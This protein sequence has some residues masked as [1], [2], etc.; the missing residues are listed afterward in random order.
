M[1]SRR[2]VAILPVIALL[3]AACTPAATGGGDCIVGVSWN[4]FQQP[5]WARTDKPAMQDA[6]EA[7]GGTFIDA[8][9]NLDALQQATDIDSMIEQGADV[10]VL[11]AQDGT[12]ILPA[13]EKAQTAGI[14]VIAYDRLLEDPDILYLTFDNQGVG[15]LEAEAIL[16]EVPTGNYVIIKGDPGDAN[17]TFLRDGF[18]VAGLQ[19]KVDAGDITIIY[20]EFTDDWSTTNAET[21]MDAAIQLA[22]SEDIE[23]DAVLSENDSM[24]LG[25]VASLTKEG[26]QGTIP[27]SGQDGD[28]ANLNNVAK[29]LQFVDVWKNSFALGQTAG[30]A[31][32]QLC[33]GKSNAEVTAP[34]DLGDVEPSTGLATVDFETPGGNTVKSIILTPTPVTFDTLDLVVDTWIPKADLCAGVDAATAPPA[35]E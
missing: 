30:E 31:A 2:L 14:P 17:A 28:F 24:A 8:D 4:N 26:L 11:L 25:V 33:D 18:D 19:D 12:A 7:G 5:R 27:V 10:L 1:L 13:L 29:G 22:K 9:A 21:N 3:V 15:V 35:C 34:D 32:L 6:I 23:I 20:E 16:A